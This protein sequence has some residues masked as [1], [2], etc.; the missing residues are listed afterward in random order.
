M[1][2]RRTI[3]AVIIV[4]LLIIVIPPFVGAKDEDARLHQKNIVV[5]TGG[6]R[7]PG[8][9]AGFFHAMDFTATELG[10]LTVE[11]EFG[12]LD[13]GDCNPRGMDAKE[14]A[15]ELGCTTG[16]TYGHQPAG[17]DR[18][19]AFGFVCE[20]P[21]HKIVRVIEALSKEILRPTN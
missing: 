21:Q 15:E 17:G 1:K 19:V 13:T 11:T 12:N 4:L 3:S 14:L 5:V 18:G 2:T 10:A 6:Y 16:P 7:C 20:G 8:A 9:F